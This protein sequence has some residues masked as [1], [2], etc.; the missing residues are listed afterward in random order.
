MENTLA[1]PVPESLVK[2]TLTNLLRNAFEHSADGVVDIH[3]KGNTLRISDT[4]SGINA[5]DLPYIFERSYTTKAD[6]TGLGLNMVRRICDRYGWHIAVQ[7]QSGKG[8]TVE[9]KF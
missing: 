1:L 3:L 5:D 6:G 2:I 8:T 9:M 7:S 4:G